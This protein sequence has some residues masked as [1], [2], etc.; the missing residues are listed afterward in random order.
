MICEDCREKTYIIYI[1]KDH[2][3]LCSDCRDKDR[4]YQENFVGREEQD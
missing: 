2:R 4:E 1:T 3:R